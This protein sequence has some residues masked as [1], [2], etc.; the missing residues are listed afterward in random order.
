MPRAPLQIIVAILIFLTIGRAHQHYGFLGALQPALLLFVAG[1]GYALLNPGSVRWKNAWSTWPPRVVAG[2]AAVACLSVPF[3]ISIGM[4][5][6]FVLNAY[7]KVVLTFF[8]LLV[9]LRH[10]D[11][12]YLFVWAYVLGCGFLVYISLFVFAL[13]ESAGLQRLGELYFY[14][15]NDLGV[16]LSAGIPLCVVLFRNSDRLGKV[17]SGFVLVGIGAS[18]ARSGSRGSFL[19]LVAVAIGL[20]FLLRQISVLKRVGA[21]LVLAAGLFFMAPQGYWTQMES[22][23]EPT[24][25]YNWT[26]YYGRKAVAERG[27]GYMLENP[28]F[29]VGVGN[30]ARAEGLPQEVFGSQAEAR[31]T[32]RW[33]AAHNSFVQA[34]AEM[35]IPG[36][37][38]FC[39]LVFGGI[40]GM[41]RLRK[42][43]PKAWRRRKGQ[44]RFVYDLATFLPV[45]WLGFAVSG[46]FVS[47]AYH[48]VTY[49]LT[50]LVAGTYL[51]ARQLAR[52]EESIPVAMPEGGRARPRAAARGGGR[53]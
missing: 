10:T 45:S 52:R 33:R 51:C 46:F 31:E 29:G 49:V 44:H 15:S 14:D 24:E 48:D 27:V 32:Y 35:G 53:G 19:G 4:A 40:F 39:G 17:V 38:L 9:A 30:F 6:S 11:D 2:L 1:A 43:L 21:V 37:L 50:V 5:G 22:L 16:V 34:G 7:S 3:A 13:Q 26:S 20:M 23:T 12:L 8:L 47:F 42:R 36:L 41:S 25:D 18:L 28:V